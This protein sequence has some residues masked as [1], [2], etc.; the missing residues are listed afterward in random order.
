MAEVDRLAE[1]HSLSESA[2]EWSGDDDDDEEE[3]EEEEVGQKPDTE[4][5]DSEEPGEVASVEDASPSFSHIPEAKQRLQSAFDTE[6]QFKLANA[7][8]TSGTDKSN[9][10]VKP[11]RNALH[12]VLSKI[13]GTVNRHATAATPELEV[14]A[15]SKNAGNFSLGSIGTMSASSELDEV[16][17]FIDTAE[18]RFIEKVCKSDELVRAAMQ[19]ITDNVVGGG[20]SVTMEISGRSIRLN[21]VMQ[22][23]FDVEWVQRFVKDL[24]WSLCMYGFVVVR[25]IRSNLIRT[26]SVPTVVSP[27]HYELTMVDSINRGREYR[28]YPIRFGE[29][30]G[31]GR[32]S[33]SVKKQEDGSKMRQARKVYEGDKS[34]A[35]YVLPGS[36]PLTDGS[37]NSP[38]K[39]IVSKLRKLEWMWE[40]LS[41]ASHWGARPTHGVNTSQGKTSVQDADSM[42]NYNPPAPVVALHAEGAQIQHKKRDREEVSASIQA[43]VQA[44]EYGVED[45]VAGGRT[46]RYGVNPHAMAAPMRNW[47]IPGLNHQLVAG[48]API[49]NP[50]IPETSKIVASLL[51]ITLGVPAEMIIPGQQVHAANAEFAM[52]RWDIVVS[53]YQ[54]I[55]EPIVADL[56]AMAYSGEIDDFKQQWPADT[57]EKWAGTDHNKPNVGGD[58]IRK[59]VKSSGAPA[60]VPMDADKHASDALKHQL[61][62]KQAKSQQGL[63]LKEISHKNAAKL[64]SERSPVIYVRFDQTPMRLFEDIWK[65]FELNLIK[66]EEVAKHVHSIYHVDP[67]M[68]L[69]K[70]DRDNQE[71]ERRKKESRLEELYG[72][73]E[74]KDAEDSS[75]P[76]SSSSSSKKKKTKKDSKAV[77]QQ[78]A[79]KEKKKSEKSKSGA[80]E[81]K[82]KSG[83]VSASK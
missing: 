70:E 27:M 80:G 45:D 52:R 37:I 10:F 74:A 66:Y 73:K 64:M 58:V 44:I 78:G 56:F 51:A 79:S 2:S 4:M 26:E 35:V 48:P 76:S 5:I 75:T 20:M 68:I 43:S 83:K 36:E 3:E 54:K 12:Q 62:S 15:H 39:T 41:R 82:G 19:I 63:G 6:I 81:G 22:R 13:P 49:F 65:L 59:H 28:V 29:D 46:G 50:H 53:G 69:S 47:F 71:E 34:L 32:V 67:S 16:E 14:V 18:M 23:M 60:N 55:I 77:G 25:L 24:L 1:A 8:A 40:D 30:G 61:L 31:T 72:P 21:Q 11:L 17:I 57:I 33:D 38:L 9:P 7:A 42:K